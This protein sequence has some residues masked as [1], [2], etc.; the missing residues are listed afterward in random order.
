MTTHK[1]ISMLSNIESESVTR[2]EAE[3]AVRTLIRWAGDDPSREGLRDTPAR[4]VRSFEEFF[5]GYL[6][7]PVTI[8]ERT[9]EETEVMTR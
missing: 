4:V 5:G 8:L 2:E 1:P 3:Q 9:F 7:D 6:I